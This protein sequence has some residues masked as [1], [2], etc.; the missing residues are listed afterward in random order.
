MGN[1]DA[2]GSILDEK[3]SWIDILYSLSLSGRRLSNLS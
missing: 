2:S 3:E 1:T